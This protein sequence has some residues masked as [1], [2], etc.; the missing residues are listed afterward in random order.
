MKGC[1]FCGRSDLKLTGEHLFAEWVYKLFHESEITIYDEETIRPLRSWKRKWTPNSRGGEKTNQVCGDCN[2]GWMSRIEEAA[3]PVL[4]PMIEGR[5]TDLSE[6]DQLTIVSWLTKTAFVLELTRSKESP[7]VFDDTHR[8]HFRQ[9]LAPPPTSYIWLGATT[10]PRT[11]SFNSNHPQM[12]TQRSDTPGRTVTYQGF[13]ATITVGHFLG[14]FFWLGVALPPGAMLELNFR[15]DAGGRGWD[16]RIIPIWP[17][18]GAKHFGPPPGMDAETIAR[19]S[20]RMA[21][22]DHPSARRN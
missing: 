12:H 20:Y 22:N 9:S 6:Q 4:T 5:A 1:A 16:D 17:L 10:S 7:I 19:F 14:Q 18:G 13:V 8:S 15:S 3:R 11:A 21:L 2:H